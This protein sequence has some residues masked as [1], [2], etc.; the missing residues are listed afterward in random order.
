L[1]GTVTTVVG[2]VAARAVLSA[3]LSEFDAARL[4][5]LRAV[6]YPRASE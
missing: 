6:R 3:S 2:L 4:N 5:G 1:S